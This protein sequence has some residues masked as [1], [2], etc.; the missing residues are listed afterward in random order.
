MD[1]QILR[2]LDERL[3]VLELFAEQIMAAIWNADRLDG[4]ARD[5]ERA[6]DER[7]SATP[8]PG[9]LPP[10]ALTHRA[11]ILREAADLARKLRTGG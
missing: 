2:G 10:R 8:F 1:E 9:L 4:M 5:A 6:A 3:A 11:K 7:E